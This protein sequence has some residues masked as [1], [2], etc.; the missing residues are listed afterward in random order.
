MILIACYIPFVIFLAYDNSVRIKKGK[1]IKHWLNGLLHTI[2]FVV[3]LINGRWQDAVALL[4]LV[5]VIFDTA[6]NLF[7]GLP[8]FKLPL[9][10]KSV[11]DKME[12]KVFAGG[13]FAKLAYLI[14]ALCLILFI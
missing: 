9:N 13:F 3:I 5:R 10:P 2:M 8:P 6:L 1:Y 4:L 14:L 12:N 7:R 11:I